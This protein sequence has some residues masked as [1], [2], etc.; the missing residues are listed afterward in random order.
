MAQHLSVVRDAL[1]DALALAFPVA[2]VACRAP[3]RALCQACAAGVRPQPRGRVLPSGLRVWSGLDYGGAA[4]AALRALKEE[5]RTSLARTL[6]P[7]LAAA[8]AA[9]SAGERGLTVVPV[10]PTRAALRRRG[11][12]VVELLARRAGAAPARILVPARRTIDQRA[13]GRAA[14]QENAAGS[15]RA[16][17]ASGLRVVVVDD[18]VTT[19]ATL[20][21]AVRAL[22]A[23]GAQVVGA[24]VVAATALRSAGRGAAFEAP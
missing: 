15:L 9:A 17:R 12:R 5:G 19:G 8:L 16:H 24:A 2:C 10:P 18:V 22:T 7:A 13:L 21:E 11:Y 3:G 4:A 14:R 23:A 20:D 6:A 1:A